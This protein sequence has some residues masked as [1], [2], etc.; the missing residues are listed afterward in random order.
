MALAAGT[1]AVEADTMARAI[2]DAMNTE[3]GAVTDDNDTF[4]RRFC[5]TIASAIVA[6]IQA[7]AD[8]VISARDAGLQRQ[9]DG[10]P[11]LAPSADVTVAG[12]VQ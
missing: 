3:F 4:R 6:H 10:T 1:T 9:S 8:V 2:Y 7:R 5:A 11:T 12:G